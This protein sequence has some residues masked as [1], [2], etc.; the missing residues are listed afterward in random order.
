M[1]RGPKWI[2]IQRRHTDSQQTHE[3]M[4]LIINHQGTS[5]QNHNEIS[6]HTYQIAIIKKT[7]NNKCWQGCGEK[8]TLMHFQWEYKLVQPLCKTGWRCLKKLKIELLY[9]P[10]IQLLGIFPEKIKH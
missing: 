3:K 5:S 4:L 10:A 2:F 8:G 7:T 6:L 9:D 1:G